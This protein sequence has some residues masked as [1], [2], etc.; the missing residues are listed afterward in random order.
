M[1][2]MLGALKVGLALELQLQR[3]QHEISLGENE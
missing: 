1:I 2:V 3:V